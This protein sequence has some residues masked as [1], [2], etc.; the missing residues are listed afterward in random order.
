MPNQLLDVW[1][2]YCDQNDLGSR[3]NRVVKPLLRPKNSKTAEGLSFALLDGKISR[4]AIYGDPGTGKTHL[5]LQI[6]RTLSEKWHQE[7]SPKIYHPGFVPTYLSAVD[8]DVKC[9]ESFQK[10]GS[11]KDAIRSLG[12]RPMLLLDDLGKNSVSERHIRDFSDLLDLRFNDDKPT[13]ITTNLVEKE[14]KEKYG[15]RV[16]SRLKEFIWVKKEG[17]DLRGN[18]QRESQ[19]D[20][21]KN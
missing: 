6:A 9:L 2:S 4:L 14:L 16:H 18:N 20:R 17:P 19:N 1:K 11:T 3:N 12:Y 21:K 15:A 7:R 13:I 5:L 10:S 8:F